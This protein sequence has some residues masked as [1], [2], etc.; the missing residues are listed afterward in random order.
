M[1]AYAKIGLIVV[2]VVLFASVSSISAK[3]IPKPL[4]KIEYIGNHTDYDSSLYRIYPIA[5][6]PIQLMHS[7]DTLFVNH[8]TEKYGELP[9]LSIVFKNINESYIY[10]EPIYEDQQVFYPKENL[11]DPFNE[12]KKVNC[13]YLGYGDYN[14]THC[15][16]TIKVKIGE[17]NETRYRLADKE[18]IR[19]DFTKDKIGNKIK[20]IKKQKGKLIKKYKFYKTKKTDISLYNQ[21]YSQYLKDGY[22]DVEVTGKPILSKTDKG[23]GWSLDHVICYEGK[24]LTGYEW[25]NSSWGACRNITIPNN[26]D[27]TDFPFLLK[28]NS[29]RIDYSKT[30]DSGQDFRVVNAGCGMGGSVVPHEI[31]LWNESGD[32]FVW[33]KGNMSS[34]STTIYSYYYDNSGASDG[35]DATNVWDDNFMGVWHMN[36]GSTST[37]LDSTR[38]NLDGTKTGANEPTETTGKIGKGQSFDGSDD[39]II[40]SN[41]DLLQFS[42]NIDFTITFF[43]KFSVIDSAILSKGQNYGQVLG[44]TIQSEDTAGKGDGIRIDANDGGSGIDIAEEDIST[45]GKGD[46]N[47]WH[48]TS[49]TMDRDGDGKVYLDSGLEATHSLSTLG[50]INTTTDL[51][52]GDRNDGWGYFHGLLDEIRI[53]NVS[54]SADWV[55]QTYLTETDALITYGTEESAPSG[56]GNSAPTITLVSPSDNTYTTDNTPSFKFNIIDDSN[57][58][59]SAELFINGTGY[60]TNTSVLNATDTTITAN[61]SLSDGYYEWWINATDGTDTT[62]SSVRSIIVDTTNPIISFSANSTSGT[63]RQNYIYYCGDLTEANPNTVGYSY[64]GTNST[65][66]D[67][68]YCKNQTSQS[69]GSYDIYLWA[70]DKVGHYSETS[71][72]TVTLDTTAPTVAWNSETTSTGIINQNYILLNCSFS[73]ATSGLDTIGYYDSTNNI[74]SWTGNDSTNYWANL[75]SLSDGSYSNLYCWA[76]DTVS[77]YAETTKKSWIIDTTS[78]S[79]FNY[80]SPTEADNADKSQNYYY[81]N[82]TF[83]EANPDSCLLD[84]GSTNTT[85]ARSGTNCYVNMTGQSDGTYTYRVYANDTAGNLGVSSDRSLTL[86]TTLPNIYVYSPTNSSYTT[87]NIALQY[88]TSET[89]SWIGYSLNSASNITLNGNTTITASQGLNSIV[90]CGND[91][92]GNMNCSETVW[93]SVDSIAPSVVITAPTGQYNDTTS[94]PIQFTATDT[95]LDLCWYTYDGGS[96]NTSLPSCSNTTISVPNGTYTMYVYANDTFGNVNSDTTNFT[97]GYDPYIP[98]TPDITTTPTSPIPNDNLQASC[99]SLNTTNATIISQELVESN[100]YNTTFTLPS[101]YNYTKLGGYYTSGSP[102][103]NYLAIYNFSSGSFDVKADNSGTCIQVETNFSIDL[104]TTD[105]INASGY[106]IIQ[107]SNQIFLNATTPIEDTG[108]NYFYQFAYTNGTIIQTYSNDPNITVEEGFAGQGINVSCYLIEDGTSEI[109]YSVANI[110]NISINT[111]LNNSVYIGKDVSFLTNYTI[112]G[113]LRC[114]E[115]LDNTTIDLGSIGNGIKNNTYTTIDYGNHTFTA[116]CQSEANSSITFSRTINFE[117]YYANWT[118]NLYTED[119]WDT[120]FNLSGT[121]GTIYIFCDNRDT[122]TYNVTDTTIEGIMPVCDVSSIG[123]VLSYATSSYLREI[124]PD[125]EKKNVTIY[126]A[127]AYS[128]TIYQIPIVMSDYNY[129]D[130]E[131]YLYKK[132]GGTEY[133]VTSGLF[134]VEH[135]FVSYLKKDNKYFLRIVDG[136]KVIEKGYLYAGSTDTQYLFLSDMGIGAST[137]TVGGNLKMGAYFLDDNTTLK[138]VYNDTLE[139]T[140]NLTVTVKDK[141]KNIVYNGTWPGADYLDLSVPNLNKTKRY[142]VDFSILHDTLGNSPVTKTIGVGGTINFI[143]GIPTWLY[144]VITLGLVLMII[145]VVVPTNRFAGLLMLGGV[146]TWAGFMGWLQTSE[147]SPIGVYSSVLIMVLIGAG[148]AYEILKGGGQ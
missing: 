137:A 29:S 16:T 106:V 36:D 131:I 117:N 73:D 58:T 42:D 94:I 2:L 88:G 80:V 48:I 18:L 67:A 25:W 44:W 90:V 134:D 20:K 72:R 147:G 132:S 124:A 10:H 91:T 76:D 32:S 70:T 49:F 129:F 4:T 78:P 100:K 83:T 113:H 138:I 85:M 130:S 74:T 111:P 98:P 65:A 63:V 135:K 116:S 1:K 62:K 51:Y 79:S 21:L 35:Q 102:C 110:T 144:I 112:N 53:S 60:G 114:S 108:T 115:T 101:G 61:A 82:V 86:D 121:T 107:T 146:M 41:N 120:P 93:F 99:L 77:N 75:T 27:L 39:R 40:V 143:L 119:D 136:S 66:W 46:D 133:M 30:Q 34:T 81:V 9:E 55:S 38:N 64:D 52:I 127:D 92:A 33:F 12:S 11:T 123:V 128:Y 6:N 19:Q 8:T 26:A 22:L 15:N 87:T 59:T 96:T 71:T 68:N 105:Y 50:N 118:L 54:R 84:D 5:H 126:L 89:T 47:I 37:I 97:A 45:N 24:C 140:E 31:E 57:S 17:T 7:L 14:K 139:E 23:W 56:G 69:D 125:P 3:Q 148:I 95:N 145:F 109:N 104:N 43:A 13:S 142:T 103:S 122:Y 28:L 141:D